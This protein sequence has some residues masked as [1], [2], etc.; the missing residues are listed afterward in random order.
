MKVALVPDPIW[1][2]EGLTILEVQRDGSAKKSVVKG[3]ITY[4]GVRTSAGAWFLEPLARFNPKADKSQY[5]VYAAHDTAIDIDL[6]GD[7]VGADTV[8]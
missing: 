7:A 4:A 8:D 2:E 5:V 6:G 3:N 1:P